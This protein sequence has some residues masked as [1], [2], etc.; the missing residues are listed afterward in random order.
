MNIG[1]IADMPERSLPALRTSIEQ[2]G[3]ACL[4]D[5][6]RADALDSLQREAEASKN[7]ALRAD[8][9]QEVSYQARIAPLGPCARAFLTSDALGS[10]LARVFDSP[11][12]C[13]ETA[14]CFTYYE[15]GD[16]LS[17]HRDRAD[18]CEFTV[19]LY[20]HT[21]RPMHVT[22]STGLLLNVYSDGP[23]QARALALVIATQTG[24]LVFGRGAAVLHERPPLSQGEAV[25][26]LTSCF[27]RC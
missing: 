22:T 27:M 20:L 3:F 25:V 18:V 12:A 16:F 14:S 2:Y 6:L 10:M 26:A 7:E 17:A 1:F 13:S 9:N 15:T 4:P 5:A 23:E 11:L 21:Q 19:I 24:S 8:G